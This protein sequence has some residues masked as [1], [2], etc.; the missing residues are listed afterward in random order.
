ML[1]IFPCVY[2]RMQR[3]KELNAKV[4]STEI[5]VN[6]NSNDAKNSFNE[7]SH[8]AKVG[9]HDTEEG[10]H[11][12]KE[13]SRYTEEDSHY[14]EE[15]SHYTEEDLNDTEEDLNDTEE[16]P[17]DTK[18][19]SH[20][21]C[22]PTAIVVTDTDSELHSKDQQNDDELENG[23]S[24]DNIEQHTFNSKDHIDEHIKKADNDGRDTSPSTPLPTICSAIGSGLYIVGMHRKMVSC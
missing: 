8:I 17:H 6:N 22:G 12:T 23:I 10:S 5:L 7:D 20:D 14:T 24:T 16:G 18:E 13:G 21:S 9:S 1:Y 19:G 11:D 3:L 2:C 15:D 4:S